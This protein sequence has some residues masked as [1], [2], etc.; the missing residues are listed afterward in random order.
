MITCETCGSRDVVG[1]E[2]RG[3]YDGVL[4]WKCHN[5]HLWPRFEPGTR[6]YDK[7]VD[8]IATWGERP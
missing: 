6:L 8:F 1:I 2:V 3:A 7:A 4:F 5:G